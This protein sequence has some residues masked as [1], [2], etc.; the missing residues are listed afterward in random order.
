MTITTSDA[1]TLPWQDSIFVGGSFVPAQGGIAVST[2]K[3]PGETLATVGLAGPD[4]VAGAVGAAKA[5][6]PS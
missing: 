2:E 6:Q 5:A 4:D 1:P 3:A